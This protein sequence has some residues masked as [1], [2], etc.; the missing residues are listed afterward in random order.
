VAWRLL[1]L[2]VASHKMLELSVINGITITRLI[3]CFTVRIC[4]LLLPLMAVLCTLVILGCWQC[5][6]NHVGTNDF[7][8]VLVSIVLCAFLASAAFSVNSVTSAWR[9]VQIPTCGWGIRSVVSLMNQ[10]AGSP[11]ADKS[12][13]GGQGYNA[14]CRKSETGILWNDDAEL[15]LKLSLILTRTL[16]LN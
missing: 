8:L 14:Q 1:A 3:V 12:P 6:T 10:L 7:L 13:C 16:T 4:D 15:T 2:A 11:F 9:E 5:C